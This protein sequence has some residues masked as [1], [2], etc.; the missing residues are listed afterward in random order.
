[1]YRPKITFRC[2]F[3]SGADLAG[4][5]L[6]G[7]IGDLRCT[8]INMAVAVNVVICGTMA[9]IVSIFPILPLLIVFMMAMGALGGSLWGLCGPLVV[10]AIGKEHA[11]LGGGITN[12]LFGI[13]TTISPLLIGKEF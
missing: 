3:I 4:R 1:M 12:S 13:S 2:L 7:A 8:N 6:F 5:L 11:G 10:D 9:F